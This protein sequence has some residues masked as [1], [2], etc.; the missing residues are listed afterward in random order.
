MTSDQL[1]DNKPSFEELVKSKLDPLYK[2]EGEKKIFLGEVE[3]VA[4]EAQTNAAQ[5]QRQQFLRRQADVY[6]LLDGFGIAEKLNHIK[7]A[8]WKRGVIEV[9]KEPFEVDGVDTGYRIAVGYRLSYHSPAVAMIEGDTNIRR[10]LW[11]DLYSFLPTVEAHS[12]ELRVPQN[13]DLD[14]LSAYSQSRLHLPAF[15]NLGA[16]FGEPAWIKEL[17]LNAYVD[18]KRFDEI[19]KL[20]GRTPDFKIPRDETPQIILA[21]PSDRKDYKSSQLFRE[22]DVAL[23]DQFLAQ[24]C[25]ERLRRGKLPLQ[26]RDFWTGYVQ[27]SIQERAANIIPDNDSARE[28]LEFIHGSDSYDVFSEKIWSCGYHSEGTLVSR[29]LVYFRKLGWDIGDLRRYINLPGDS[30]QYDILKPKD[31]SNPNKDPLLIPLVPDPV[32][33]SIDDQMK[34]KAEFEKVYGF[35]FDN[36][37]EW[38]RGAPKIV[39][40]YYS[41]DKLA[42]IF[43][44]LNRDLQNDP[45]SQQF[46]VK[47]D[48]LAIALIGAHY[49]KGLLERSR[50]YKDNWPKY[51][52]KPTY[53]TPD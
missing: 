49:H 17:F 18:G 50:I 26:T 11:P 40:G 15:R 7:G 52:P 24:D 1:G 2:Q 44:D 36:V 5:Q 16:L 33:P 31:D 27:G 48:E 9:I 4:I 6:G 12:V 39:W 22:D 25:A 29:N 21:K 47:R 20:I 32:D 42:E 19:T 37:V 45:Y 8:V 23:V 30:F 10:T 13:S 34:Y 46:R 14:T 41:F 35:D 28:W 51:S 43:N 53:R 3:G 38:F